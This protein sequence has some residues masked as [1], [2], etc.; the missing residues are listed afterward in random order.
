MKK[1][2]GLILATTL[3]LAL[4]LTGVSCASNLTSTPT[5]TPTQIVTPTPTPTSTD[6]KPTQVDKMKIAEDFIKNSST[7]KYDGMDDSIMLVKAEDGYTAYPS[8]FFTFEFQTRHPGHG[9][10]TGQILAQV[11]TKHTV[12]VLVVMNDTIKSAICDGEWDMLTDKAIKPAETVIPEGIHALV[13]DFIKNTATFKFDGIADSM[14]I[15]NSIDKSSPAVSASEYEFTIAF[16]TGHPGHGDR[17]GQTLD[18]V[19]TPHRAVVI[20]KIGK[21]T[22]AICDGDYDLLA[23][24]PIAI[25]VNGTIVS[26][27]DTSQPGGPI[28]TPHIFTWKIQKA[29]GTF[30]NVS[31]TAYPP[32]P[33]GDAQKKK[34]T[35]NFRG[36]SVQVGDI[37][38]ARGH[39][40]KET[41][42]LIVANEGDY[43]YTLISNEN[44]QILATDFIK[45]SDAT[46]KFDGVPGNLKFIKTDPGLTS[47]F[48][49]ISFTF[50]YQTQH[51]GHGDRTGQVLAQVITDHTAIILVN[52]EKGIVM[53]AACDNTWD[54]IQNKD[55]PVYI[56][57][58]I[59]SGGDTTGADGPKDAPR[60]FVY[61][62]QKDDGNFVNISYIAYPPSP[63]GDANR[64]K[65]TLDFHAGT[66]IIGDYVNASGMLDKTTNVIACNYIKTMPPKLEV[67]GKVISGGD[68][69][70]AGGPQDAPRKF[71]YKIQKDNGDF[72]NVTYTAYP[73]SPSGDAAMA[74]INLSYYD[75]APKAGDY[76]KAYGTYDVTSSTITVVDDGDFIKTYPVKP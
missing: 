76:I 52:I 46:F 67:V 54:M 45:N 48:R 11:I 40:N 61:K 36:G 59:I 30:M 9:D 68:T 71:V 60:T 12:V 20:V 62:V 19:I 69:T 1:I 51:P 72:L 32:S 37:M 27:G 43:I 53:S 58:Y 70:A 16:Q 41:N 26:G 7:F 39:F 29:D 73:P 34:I 22:S 21:V 31:Y 2:Y 5:P 15:V 25:T 17:S 57:G 14:K 66:I 8:R 35:L 33:V 18:L 74:K 6:T 75:G 63:V 44:A 42:T 28:D 56:Y 65:I 64:D 49:S 47:S 4:L 24:K 10:R 50:T 55:L 3:I 38:H 13:I 23:D